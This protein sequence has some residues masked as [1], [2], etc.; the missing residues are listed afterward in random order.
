L[1]HRHSRL[2]FRQYSHVYP[3]IDI[4]YYQADNLLEFGWTVRPGA[5]PSRIRMRFP[6]AEEI[7]LDGD[8]DVILRAGDASTVRH[9]PRTYQK[10]K[11]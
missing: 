6:K 7:R 10:A 8:G 5:D 1:A 4:T 9:A 11:P 3:G 2:F